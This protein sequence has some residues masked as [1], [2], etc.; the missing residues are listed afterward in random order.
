MLCVVAD[1]EFRD[2]ALF[3]DPRPLSIESGVM[4]AAGPLTAVFPVGLI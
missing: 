2:A 1:L 3:K 4:A